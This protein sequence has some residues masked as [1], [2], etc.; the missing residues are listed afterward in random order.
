MLQRRTHLAYSSC[1]M[2]GCKSH[3]FRIWKLQ[4]IPWQSLSRKTNIFISYGY[5]IAF[6]SSVTILS[7]SFPLLHVK[8]QYVS[9]S[10]TERTLLHLWVV[11]RLTYLVWKKNLLPIAKLVFSFLHA[12]LQSASWLPILLGCHRGLLSLKAR[13]NVRVV[14]ALKLVCYTNWAARF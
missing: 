2:L 12:S 1:F 5:G 11:G 10:V 9:N 13:D 7:F 14:R 3:R 6:I 4:K 8:P